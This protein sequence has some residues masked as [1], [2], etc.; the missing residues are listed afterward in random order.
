MKNIPFKLFLML[1]FFCLVHCQVNG[2]NEDCLEDCPTSNSTCCNCC[3]GGSTCNGDL[4]QRLCCPAG[5]AFCGC[6]S[7]RAFC[8]GYVYESNGMG[9]KS[10]FGTCFDP[11]DPKTSKCDY[12]PAPNLWIVCPLNFTSCKSRSFFSCCS[13]SEECTTTVSDDIPHCNSKIPNSECPESCGNQPCC[14]DQRLGLT[15]YNP[16]THHC[17][18]DVPSGL[19]TLCGI[20]DGA[21]GHWCYDA[22]AYACN[23]D[24]TLRHL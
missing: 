2:V 5:A 6:L 8:S 3:D 14:D 11:S 7:D 22:T 24:G 23:N 17:V 1:S 16:H 15:C 18:K 13:P 12:E 4:I 21:C 9:S 10:P 19:D 20:K